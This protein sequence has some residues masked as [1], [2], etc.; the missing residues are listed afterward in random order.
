MT[1]PPSYTLLA[2]AG[3]RALVRDDV[4]ARLGAWLVAPTLAAP[5][6]ARPIDSGRGGAYRV[7]MGDGLRLVVRPCRRGGV[8]GRVVTRT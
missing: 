5:R 2:R 1:V 7:A 3:V 8:L 4:V 6:D